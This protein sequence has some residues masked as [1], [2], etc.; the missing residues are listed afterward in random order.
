MKTHTT[1][2][3]EYKCLQVIFKINIYFTFTLN[4]KT[5]VDFLRYYIL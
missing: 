3:D 4:I 2:D 1:R 5:K